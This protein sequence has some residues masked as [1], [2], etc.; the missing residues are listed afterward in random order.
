[1]RFV[2]LLQ[3]LLTELLPSNQ[4]GDW[5]VFL[6]AKHE[7]RDGSKSD[8]VGRKWSERGI[9]EC[10]K[11]QTSRVQSTPKLQ[12]HQ[13]NEKYS[14]PITVLCPGMLITR[15]LIFVVKFDAKLKFN[16]QNDWNTYLTTS[17][18]S[19]GHDT[20]PLASLQHSVAT[21][22]NR[23]RPPHQQHLPASQSLSASK[24]QENYYFPSNKKKSLK[25]TTT[26]SIDGLSLKI[27]RYHLTDPKNNDEWWWSSK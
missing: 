26:N 8:H 19:N 18:T 16:L 5:F 12:L 20:K 11:W 15:A 23:G 22:S 25:W 9:F 14:L 10:K 13:S 3:P 27:L 1:M 4:S 2:I 7:S 6:L 21:P 17:A 24:F